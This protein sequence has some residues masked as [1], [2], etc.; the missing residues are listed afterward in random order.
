[1]LLDGLLAARK[2]VLVDLVLDLVGRVVHVNAGV[3]VRRAHLRLRALQCGEKFGV[4]QRGLRVLELHGDVARQ[5]EVRV[6]VDRARD[7]ARD[8]GD[9]A[10]DLGE[11]VGEGG[12]GLDG[13]EVDLAD[14]VSA[15]ACVIWL[16][17]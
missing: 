9:G 17:G 8:V 16:D 4:Q 6:L 3:R 5:P 7:E 15:D 2:A 1:M 14:V 11:G 12:R 10:E 13:R